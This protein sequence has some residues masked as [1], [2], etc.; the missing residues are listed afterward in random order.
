MGWNK[1][2]QIT[3]GFQKY[4]NLKSRGPLNMTRVVSYLSSIPVGSFNLIYKNTTQLKNA[5]EKRSLFQVL[6]ER[7]E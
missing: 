2:F 6:S 5:G 3:F 1:P 7:I 4:H